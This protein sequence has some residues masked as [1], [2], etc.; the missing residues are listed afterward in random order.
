MIT[1]SI[2]FS[3]LSI[4]VCK[5]P[6]S[7]CIIAQVHALALQGTEHRESSLKYGSIRRALCQDTLCPDI[8]GRN[9]DQEILAPARDL[10]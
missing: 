10:S 4:I 8:P 2:P 1:K 7:N 6:C 9:G 5:I 3:R